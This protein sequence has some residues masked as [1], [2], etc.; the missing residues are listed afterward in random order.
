V[1]VFVF[2]FLFVFVSLLFVHCAFFVTPTVFLLIGLILCSSFVSDCFTQVVYLVVLYLTIIPYL[3]GTLLGRLDF[4]GIINTHHLYPYYIAIQLN[5]S[6]FALWAMLSYFYF[7]VE[8]KTAS[9]KATG[10]E[11]NSKNNATEITLE[12]EM[13][14]LDTSKHHDY[15]F[16]SQEFAIQDTT[17]KQTTETVTEKSAQQPRYSFNIF[18]GTCASGAFASFIHDGDSDDEKVDNAATEHWAAVQGHI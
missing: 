16:T 15:I 10:D 12:N 9:T 14:T 18:D 11:N 13:N 7:S 6:I 1:F 3:I 4:N 8:K 2:V 5:F 17:P